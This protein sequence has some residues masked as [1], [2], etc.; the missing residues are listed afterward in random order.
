MQVAIRTSIFEKLFKTHSEQT[1]TVSEEYYIT[2]T[3]DT[4]L[5]NPSYFIQK[6]QSLTKALY[7]AFQTILER[8]INM[9]KPVP[10]F[11]KQTLL[12]KKLFGVLCVFEYK[13][14]KN[15]TIQEVNEA[16]RDAKN[17]AIETFMEFF[18]SGT[19]EG[20]PTVAFTLFKEKLQ[21]L[22]PRTETISFEPVKKPKEIQPIKTKEKSK[23]EEVEEEIKKR[24]N[25]AKVEAVEYA[26]QEIK[27]RKKAL[28]IAERQHILKQAF[29]VLKRDY[30]LEFA[31][32]DF[33]KTFGWPEAVEIGEKLG[34]SNNFYEILCE[35]QD[36]E[37]ANTI[38]SMLFGEERTL[39]ISKAVNGGFKQIKE[40]EK[41]KGPIQ[42][43]KIGIET[44]GIKKTIETLMKQGFQEELPMQQR[45][46][47]A[48]ELLLYFCEV[49]KGETFLRE[50]ATKNYI[51]LEKTIEIALEELGNEH[52]T[53]LLIKTFENS[54]KTN[55]LYTNKFAKLYNQAIQKRGKN[56]N[57]MFRLFK[58]E[59]EIN[60][61]LNNI[62]ERS[63]VLGT[64][65]KRSQIFGTPIFA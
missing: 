37:V 39:E 31:V 13:L 25:K 64:E 55:R 62:M 21:K 51:G 4:I 54:L 45:I 42:A 57:D 38:Y 50:M 16:Y 34:F 12:G 2:K 63:S 48:K 23:E 28:K 29:E 11:F 26:I 35:K 6:N 20:N 9:R 8:D 18:E 24:L 59:A 33:A 10:K 19:R 40:I 32:N 36:E 15:F 3:V 52:G 58:H 47:R 44:M 65:V 56:L 49:N 61:S 46:E 27:D 5:K 7:H 43:I 30:S 1:E 53:K 41:E 14:R 17:T 60:K 22:F